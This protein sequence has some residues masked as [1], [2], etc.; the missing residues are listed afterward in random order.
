MDDGSYDPA[1]GAVSRVI[2]IVIT[3]FTRE[4]LFL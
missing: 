4:E 2:T 3:S 1:L